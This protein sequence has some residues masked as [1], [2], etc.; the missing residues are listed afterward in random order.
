MNYSFQGG[1]EIIQLSW[2]IMQTTHEQR[3]WFMM[4]AVDAGSFRTKI[5]VLV[6]KECIRQPP[7][8]LT[9]FGAKW[10]PTSFRR[11]GFRHTF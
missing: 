1:A 9:S 5:A 3:H 11:K 7:I 2:Q 10:S 6:I 8:M 4:T